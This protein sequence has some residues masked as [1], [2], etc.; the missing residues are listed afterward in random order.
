MNLFIEWT[1]VRRKWFSF[2]VKAKANIARLANI[3][4]DETSKALT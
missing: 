1:W 2:T 4:Q 3:V